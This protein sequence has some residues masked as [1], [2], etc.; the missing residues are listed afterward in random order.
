VTNIKTRTIKIKKLN[1]INTYKKL[2]K[3]NFLSQPG[4]N[5]EITKV[6]QDCY[7]ILPEISGFQKIKIFGIFDGHGITGE[8]ISAEVK[9]Y[10]K[11]Y[12][13]KCFYLI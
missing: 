12:F 7:F 13:I 6:N 11:N 5:N 2:I 9:D 10:F 4:S 3:I 1:S 8:K